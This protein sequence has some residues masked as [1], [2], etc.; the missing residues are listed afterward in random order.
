MFEAFFDVHLWISLIVIMGTL[1][2]FAVVGL[3]VVR[4]CLLP[5]LRIQVEDSEF[6]GAIMQSVMVFYG[7]AVA[8][9]A[10]SVFET[11]SDVSKIVSQEATALA[12][13]S[14]IAADKQ[15]A[16]VRWRRRQSHAHVGA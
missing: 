11:Y 15:D 2:T 14:A 4:R 5:R 16:C 8:L 13:S 12:A 9:I 6:T 1:C 10:V 7:L 3:L